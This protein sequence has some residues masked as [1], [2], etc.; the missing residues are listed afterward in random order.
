MKPKFNGAK[1]VNIGHAFLDLMSPQKKQEYILKQQ[2]ENYLKQQEQ[3]PCKCQIRL[4]TAKGV[5]LVKYQM[6][7]FKPHEGARM[8]FK[9]IGME[10]EAGP[11]EY[12]FL[13]EFYVVPILNIADE[14]I[15]ILLNAG[16]EPEK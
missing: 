10:F 14:I 9:K 13:E 1:V 11:V 7:P 6:S 5:C 16:F 4:Y 2:K 3:Q 15:P 12:N 8:F